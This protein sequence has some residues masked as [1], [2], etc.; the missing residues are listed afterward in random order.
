MKGRL[1]GRCD[2][3]GMVPM[4][5][6]MLVLLPC[7]S[8]T[9]ARG[10]DDGWNQSTHVIKFGGDD[11][12]GIG[13]KQEPLTG[14]ITLDV[15]AQVGRSSSFNTNISIDGIT[16]KNEM[17]LITVTVKQKVLDNI[18]DKHLQHVWSPEEVNSIIIQGGFRGTLSFLSKRGVKNSKLKSVHMPVKNVELFRWSSAS[19]GMTAL[20][21]LMGIAMVVV[22]VCTMMYRC[23]DSENMRKRDHGDYEEDEE[24]VSMDEEEE[25]EED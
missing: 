9:G 24:C 3:G 10:E 5:A 21:C 2:M 6:L 17:L 4:V 18:P 8:T 11:W 13:D 25:D 22:F 1:L 7:V 16:V 19:I 23:R 12:N 15:Y 14:V 20:G